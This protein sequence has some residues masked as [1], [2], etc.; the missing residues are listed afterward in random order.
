MCSGPGPRRLAVDW[1]FAL[2][3]GPDV[4]RADDKPDIGRDSISL[5]RKLSFVTL[6]LLLSI[7]SA[8]RDGD[9]EN[10]F[11]FEFYLRVIMWIIARYDLLYTD[12]PISSNQT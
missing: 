10:L 1:D 3:S 2:I 8:R 7:E 5:M 12:S 4:P 11:R 6:D 9:R